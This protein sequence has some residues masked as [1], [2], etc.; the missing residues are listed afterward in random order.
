MKYV[1]PGYKSFGAGVDSV[2]FE[3]TAFDE[4]EEAKKA[5]GGVWRYGDLTWIHTGLANAML[6]DGSEE[7]VGVP[8]NVT[9][10]ISFPIYGV[11]VPSKLEALALYNGW[12]EEIE[13]QKEAAKPHVVNREPLVIEGDARLFVEEEWWDIEFQPADDD[14]DNEDDS[15]PG[16]SEAVTRHII[17]RE[18]RFHE[19][20]YKLSLGRVRI[21]VELLDDGGDYDPYDYVDD[22]DESD[23]DG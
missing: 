1:V 13:R 12:L 5:A 17:G 4:L 15:W 10:Y 3:T 6:G 16:L 11:N 19:W 23:G 20:I 18:L 9:G 7:W 21:T 2:E 14:A 8:N 22:D